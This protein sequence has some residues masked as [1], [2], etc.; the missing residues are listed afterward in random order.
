MLD[1]PEVQEVLP[2]KR[3]TEVV[4][5]SVCR[6]PK[7][8]NC[9]ITRRVRGS[10]HKGLTLEQLDL[11]NHLVA[12]DG[13]HSVELTAARVVVRCECFVGVDYD[14]VKRLIQSLVCESRAYG[15]A[16]A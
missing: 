16:A 13:I 7:A 6:F 2:R 12:I 15:F 4:F 3:P 1:Q 11:I 5:L 14:R 9:K 8:M 10:D